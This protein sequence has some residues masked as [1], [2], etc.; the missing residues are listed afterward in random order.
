MLDDSGGLRY[1]FRA[2]G[3][4]PGQ[5]AR[6]RRRSRLIPRLRLACR[7]ALGELEEPHVRVLDAMVAD[8]PPPPGAAGEMA[9]GAW[10]LSQLQAHM[11][12][13]SPRDWSDHGDAR[14]RRHGD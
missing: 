8:T 7:A 1:A 3:L 5:G 4:C 6:Q 9:S 12:G 2:E 13:L 10:C 11:P 14:P